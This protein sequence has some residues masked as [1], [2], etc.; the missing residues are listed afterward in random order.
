MTQGR[1]LRAYG[2]L[3]AAQETR[4][5][6]LRL[7]FVVGSRLTVVTALEALAG[8][9]VEQGEVVLAIHMLSAASTLLAQMGTP[10]RPIDRPPFKETFS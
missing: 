7:A 3:A 2:Q 6:A 10:L 4:T 8:V 5:E 9:R 1:I